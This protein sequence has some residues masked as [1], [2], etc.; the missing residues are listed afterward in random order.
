M[1]ELL[2]EYHIDILSLSI[3][4]NPSVSKQRSIYLFQIAT[5]RLKD[6]IIIILPFLQDGYM[7]AQQMQY[8]KT[9]LYA[10][11]EKLRP[12]AVALVDS[13]NFSDRELHSV[14]G[15]RDGIVYPNL[16]EWAKQSEINKSD[17]REDRL[18]FQ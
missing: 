16:L 12:N 4:F 9:G 7:A 15:R 18:R 6:F 17:V 14:L 5:I 2:W 1:N 8:V 13:F 3:P 10:S 11:L